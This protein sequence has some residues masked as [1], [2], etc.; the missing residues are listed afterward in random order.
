[1]S[2]IMITM[3]IGQF[4]S[5]PCTVRGVHINKEIGIPFQDNISKK[6]LSFEGFH[7]HPISVKVII[8]ATSTCPYPMRTMF[9]RCPVFV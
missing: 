9:L 6:P 1:M 5:V 7:F 3:C 2:C 4:I 8:A